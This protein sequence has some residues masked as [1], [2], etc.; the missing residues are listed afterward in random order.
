MLSSGRRLL[1][2]DAPVRRAGQFWSKGQWDLARGP[3][4]QLVLLGREEGFPLAFF[5][6]LLGK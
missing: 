4:P 1:L 6:L 3:Q 2:S 5:L